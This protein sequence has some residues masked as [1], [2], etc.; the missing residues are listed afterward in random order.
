MKEKLNKIL[1]S[2]FLIF[3]F[4]F[5][6]LSILDKNE[7]ISY[8]ERRKLATF[9]IYQATTD[10]SDKLEKYLLD[11]FP[12]RDKFR[13]IKAYFNFN[14]AM[15][16]ENNDIYLKDNY[17]FKSDYPTNYKS[18][19]NY[20]DYINKMKINFTEN[21]NVYIL[22]IPDKNYY[23][24][25][26][27]FLNIDYD[28]LYDE[29]SKLNI[30]N[31]DVRNI[32]NLNDYY[33]TDTHWKQQNLDKVIKKITSEMNIK[34][35]NINYKQNIYNKFYGVYYGE[36][37][38]NRNPEELIYLTNDI[39]NNVTVKYLEN[40]DLHTI[41]NESK[42]TGLDSYDVYLDGAS[43]F[44][45]IENNKATTDREL[46]IFRDSFG[47]SITPLLVNYYKKITVID[48]RYISSNYFKDKIKFNNQ[49]VIFLNSTLLVNKSSALK[50]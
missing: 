48:N 45:E 10:Y 39:L 33:E 12:F 42:L 19:D 8:S 50:K 5:S 30:K 22:I 26:D 49:D 2:I 14:I 38:I 1:I 31:I 43:S 9:P 15:K 47:S 35:E 24:E 18:I 3:I 27:N 17:I 7:I 28:Y 16:K 36:S 20:I 41:Y 4:G 13:M 6:I 44:I 25:D 40:N 32:L 34:Y 29:I 23:L 11:H 21:N 46:V 37:A